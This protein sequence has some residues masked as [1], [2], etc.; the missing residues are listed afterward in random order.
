MVKHRRGAARIGCL[1]MLL[2]VTAIGYF[3][4]NVGEVYFNFY[5]KSGSRRR[6]ATPRSSAA[7]P[8]M[9]TRLASRTRRARSL[10]GVASTTFSSTRITRLTSNCRASCAR[11]TSTPRPRGRSDSR[12][13]GRKARPAPE[14]HDVGRGRCLA[15]PCA[16]ARGFHER[17]IRPPA[18]GTRR[19]APRCPRRGEPP[20]GGAQQ[21]RIRAPAR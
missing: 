17:R 16:R 10:S 14:N 7:S 6:T 8:R 11:S 18:P 4:F 1:L 19:L 20:R 3:G 9:P 2:V 13:R 15:Q 12:S 5:R 21:R